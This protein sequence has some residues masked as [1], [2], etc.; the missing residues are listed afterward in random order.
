VSAGQ[1]LDYA[2]ASIALGVPIGSLP[3]PPHPRSTGHGEEPRQQAGA[4]QFDLIASAPGF[5]EDD[6]GQVLGVAEGPGA[7]AV[8][9]HGVV[10]AGEQLTE[11]VDVAG[12]RSSPQLI[13][14]SGLGGVVHRG[15]T[16]LWPR[17]RAG[18][19]PSGSAPARVEP[20]L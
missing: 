7:V 10:V 11:A 14:T 3:R 2:A 12:A 4:V 17:T 20:D 15:P 18:S 1:G 9:T 16:L 8:G 6:G 5:E 19:I 13:V